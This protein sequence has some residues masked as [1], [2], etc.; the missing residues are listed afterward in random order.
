MDYYATHEFTCRYTDSI[1]L[2]LGLTDEGTYDYGLANQTIS[3]LRLAKQ[4]NRSFFLMAGF[5]RP[6]LPWRLPQK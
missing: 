4:T 1:C 6:H 3:N 5:R 2:P